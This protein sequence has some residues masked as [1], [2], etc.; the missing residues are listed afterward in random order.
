M[1][2]WICDFACTLW[3][4]TRANC[5]LH[6]SSISTIGPAFGCRAPQNVALAIRLPACVSCSCTDSFVLLVIAK[7]QIFPLYKTV[8]CSVATFGHSIK[9]HMT[10]V[11]RYIGWSP[12]LRKIFVYKG[13]FRATLRKIIMRNVV[14]WQFFSVGCWPCQNRDPPSHTHMHSKYL[15]WRT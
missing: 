1:S 12:A 7:W 14:S 11:T 5:K 6:E 9:R 10:Y 13:N 2:R 3:I 15:S 8:N 4:Q